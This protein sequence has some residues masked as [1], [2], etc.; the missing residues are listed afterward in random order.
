ME[1]KLSWTFSGN[2]AL[3]LNIRH[4]WLLGT[5]KLGESR[6]F[7]MQ[8]TV[9]FGL[10][11]WSTVECVLAV[12]FIWGDLEQTTLVL[13][14]TFTCGAGVVK[15]FIFVTT[16][17]RYDSLT[18]R[19]DALL[20]L[21]TGPCSEDPALPAIADWSRRKA[22]RL[23]MGLLL[24]MLSQSMVWY[25][26]PLI[27]HPEERSLPFVQHPWDDGGLFGLAYGVQCLSAAYVSQ[28][29]F[30][31]DCLF[32]AVMILV[33]T[34]LEILGQRLVNLRNG[35][36]V[37]GRREKEQLARK[38]GESMYDD[39]RLCVETHQEILRFMTQLQD[40]MSPMAMTQFAV[41]VVIVCMALFQAT[42]SEDISAV[43]KCVLFLPIPT[44][45]VYLYCWAANNVTEQAEAVSA[46]AYSCNWVDASERFKQSMRIILSRSQKPLVL[47]AGR[48]YPINREAFLSLVNASYSYYTLLSQMNDR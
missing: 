21:Q 44:G 7:K 47:R 16:G 10:S 3:K 35:R 2:S 11:I 12:Y 45:Q 28:I 8:S 17:R 40:T 32:A 24:F 6:L 46:A 26:V 34:Q 13:L 23:T 9:A 31:V 36:R 25:F 1:D 14:I 22:S 27:A 19:L 42:F 20:S 29:S 4:L 43:L 41:S 48:L 38:T 33:A 5:W 15:M 37:A 18:L 39:L 30:G